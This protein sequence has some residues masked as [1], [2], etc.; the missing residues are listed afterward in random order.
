MKLTV[1]DASFIKDEYIIRIVSDSEGNIVGC[2]RSGGIFRIENKRLTAYY[3]GDELGTGKISTVFAD[4]EKAG[5]VYLG[6]EK[7]KIY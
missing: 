2:T 7:N 6:T 1:L 3:S 4:P 5:Y